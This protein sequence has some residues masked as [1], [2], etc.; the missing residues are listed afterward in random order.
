[1]REFGWKDYKVNFILPSSLRRILFRKS[2][3]LIAI[4][5]AI[6]KEVLKGFETQIIYNGI[7]DLANLSDKPKDLEIT[8]KKPIVFSIIGQ[9][10]P[11]KGQM[12]AVMAFNEYYKKN[13]NI[14]MFIVGD[15]NIHF[16][17]ELKEYI[18][19]H[20]LKDAV[21]FTGFIKDTESIY[22]MTDIFLM[23]SY[24]EAMGR[25]TVEA[26]AHGIPVVGYAGGAT[27]EIIKEVI[28]GYLYHN[29]EDYVALSVIMEAMVK[30]P[31]IYTQLST[32]ALEHSKR[33]NKEEYVNTVYDE[34]YKIYNL[35]N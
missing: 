31:E 25:V 7:V 3:K 35:K 32:G 17:N 15:G 18:S 16:E 27:A 21:T 23:C 1:V 12:I 28:N 2:T 11:T 6:A 13:K 29:F 14:Q 24:S 5:E 26:L 4:S 33:F 30:N 10:M 19:K 22:H 20:G 9:L 8:L 34:L